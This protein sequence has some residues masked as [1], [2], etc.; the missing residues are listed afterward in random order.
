MTQPTEPNVGT[1]GITCQVTAY[2]VEHPPY[3][4]V[5]GPHPWLAI[6]SAHMYDPAPDTGG[7]LNA[8]AAILAGEVMRIFQARATA[9]TQGQAMEAAMSLLLSRLR[10]SGLCPE[11]WFE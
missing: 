9:K 5:M 4:G 2:H 10:S 7:R 8:D 1:P 6:A 11:H 3:D